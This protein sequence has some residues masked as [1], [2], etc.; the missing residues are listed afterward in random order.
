M[1][2]N[3]DVCRGLALSALLFTRI[4]CRM[5]IWSVVDLPP[6]LVVADKICSKGR[7][8]AEQDLGQDLIGWH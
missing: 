4:C 7:K 2:M 8:S 3:R 6:S 1:L 5:K